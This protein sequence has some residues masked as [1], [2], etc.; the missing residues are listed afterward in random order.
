M[1]ARSC[2]SGRAHAQHKYPIAS[3]SS[4]R[5]TIAGICQ[6]YGWSA[7]VWNHIDWEAH[8][9]AIKRFNKKRIH[10]T[11]VIFSTWP[12]PI[13]LSIG[14]TRN[15]KNANRATHVIPKIATMPYSA[16]THNAT[17]GGQRHC[18]NLNINVR[19]STAI[20]F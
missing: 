11:K 19:H 14:T 7:V 9:M 15:S 4:D 3:Q 18:L 1:R 20:P 6:R 12:L 2:T 17:P 13:K 8:H 10:I 16:L 5:P